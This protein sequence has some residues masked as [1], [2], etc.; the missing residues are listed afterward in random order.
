MKK[1][2]ILCLVFSLS[3]VSTFARSNKSKLSKSTINKID[4]TLISAPVDNEVCFSPDERCDVKLIKFIETAEKSIDIAIY[5]INLESLVHVLA[6]K[7]KKGIKIRVVVDKQQSKERHSHVSTLI[8]AGVD[9]KI[10]R[11]R[12]FMHEKFV[13]ID[14]KR[15]ETGSFNYTHHATTANHENQVYLSTPNIVDRFQKQFDEIWT[16]AK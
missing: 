12:G 11:Q 1:L 6:V 8:K 10:G 3:S 9:V 5:S 14:N 13:I 15:L 7:L 2:I 16:E 4:E